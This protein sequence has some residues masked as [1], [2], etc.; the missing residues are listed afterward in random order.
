MKIG[1]DFG[2]VIVKASEGEPFN[3]KDGLKIEQHGAIK[4]LSSLNK[5]N[6]VF[7]VSKAS[8]RV[9]SFTREWLSVIGF[10]QKTNFRPEN[11]FFCQKRKEKLDICLNLKNDGATSRITTR[12]IYTGV[13]GDNGDWA[14]R[15]VSLH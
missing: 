9:Q 12:F 6:E 7:I 15:V 5:D 10:Y 4:A 8:Q 2:G 14:Y 3:S 13:C 11:L 1:V